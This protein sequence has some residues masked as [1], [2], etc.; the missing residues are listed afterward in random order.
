MDGSKESV[1]SALTYIES[2]RKQLVIKDEASLETLN[3]LITQ[4][5]SCAEKDYTSESYAQMKLTL[6]EMKSLDLNNLSSE[7]LKE[8][9]AKLEL[10]Q[11]Q[12]VSVKILNQWLERANSFDQ[13]LYTT[14]SYKQLL[15]SVEKAKEVLVNGT[16]ET[17]SQSISSLEE[18]IQNLAVKVK[19]EDAKTYIEQ[20]ILEDA[21]NYTE[22]SY[23]AYKDAY[24]ALIALSKDLDDVSVEEFNQ[25]K[26]A[27]EN[28]YKGLVEK[29][30]ESDKPNPETPSTNDNS[31]M[32]VY[33]GLLGASAIALLV[34][35]RKK[36][37]ECF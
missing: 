21:S 29:T 33:L 37:K 30:T 22:E 24:D 9:I 4:L 6:N 1:A 15:D 23:Q 16:S 25:A 36:L 18:A 11:R 12:L 7:Q 32:G 26:A 28:A 31:M 5:E 14:S 35:L 20:L 8:A 3:A 27:F 34:I 2:A 13:M 10:A 17:V 19:D